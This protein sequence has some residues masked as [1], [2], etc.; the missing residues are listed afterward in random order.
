MSKQTAEVETL[1]V[2][3]REAEDTIEAI[4]EGAVDALVIGN[5]ERQRV[6]TLQTADY[7]YRVLIES[8]N[9]AALTIDRKG[10]ILYSNSQFSR[11]VDQPLEQVIGSS[12][13]SFFKP[14][15]KAVVLDLIAQQANPRVSTSSSQSGCELEVDLPG[16]S[17]MTVIISA[18]RLPDVEANAY[19]GIIITDISERKKS[20]KA[21]DE[22]ISLAS[23]QLRTPA[24]GVKQ[25]LNMLLDGYAGALDEQQQI[26]IRTAN[27]SN[28]RQLKV[29]NSI[30]KT[31]QIDSG[32]YSVIKKTQNLAALVKTVLTDL[33]PVIL[34]RRQQVSHTIEDDLEVAVD[35]A[36]LCLALSNIIENASKYSPEAKKIT[37]KARQTKKATVITITD[38]GV[39][40]DSS[41]HAKI[42]EKFTRVDNLVSDTVSGSGLGLYW[43]KRIV[44]M[45]GGSITV[46]SKLGKGTSFIITLPL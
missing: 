23:H 21:K 3:L 2:R 7:T 44:A 6:Y 46:K 33:E 32:K 42:F 24:T 18:T 39:G 27:D 16:D 15:D 9:Q 4:R 20:E 36:E 38:Q 43:T 5:H 40:I 37:I 30:L 22:F 45:H 10:T 28:E 13:P 29:I 34:M 17:L 41:D 35:G 14:Q 11:M 26:F 1:R 12:L 19:M 25:Y 8:M 31:A